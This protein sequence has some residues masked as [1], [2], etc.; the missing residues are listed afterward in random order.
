M[1]DRVIRTS[2]VLLALWYCF[3]VIGFN[4][5]T[6][7]ASDS[8][9]VATFV[10][11]LSCSDIHPEHTCDKEKCCSDHHDHCCGQLIR[12]ENCCTDDHMSLDITGF[13]S[14]DDLRHNSL[15]DCGFMT[16]HFS[17]DYL[18]GIPELLVR[19]SLWHLSVPIV[20]GDRQSLLNIWRI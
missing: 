6:C 19:S 8:S 12:S 3:S 18:H 1:K 9:F 2:A 20:S 10:G 14:D 13:V 17:D 4:V 15:S 5:H 16:L 7:K 11:G